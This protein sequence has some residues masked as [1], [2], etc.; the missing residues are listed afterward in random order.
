V[1]NTVVFSNMLLA[2]A[3]RTNVVTSPP[4]RLEKV[5]S[6]SSLLIEVM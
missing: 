4:H 5:T 1:P 6:G 2:F 3:C